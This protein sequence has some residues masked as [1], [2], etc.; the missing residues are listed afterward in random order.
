[1]NW[2]SIVLI[3]GLFSLLAGCAGNPSVT[4]GVNNT[5]INDTQAPNASELAVGSVE[6]VEVIHFHRTQQCYSCITVGQYAEE[7]VN[8][9]FSE[10]L[11][12][13]RIT[14]AH[15][16]VELPENQELVTRYEVTGSSLWIGVYDDNGFHKEQNTQVWYKIGNK[17][18][19]MNYLKGII[20]KRLV[21]DYS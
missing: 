21:G 4:A 19:Y 10:E 13:G 5:Q 2:S 11:K 20:Q 18:E 9:Y 15:V 1:M 17:D 6:R 12:S 16:N 14:F 3:V 7:T 8:T